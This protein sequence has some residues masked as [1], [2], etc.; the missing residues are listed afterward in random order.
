MKNYKASLKFALWM[1]P[2]VL[3]ATVISF[4]F[5]YDTMKEAFDML[6][7]QQGIPL[8]V[9]FLSGLLQSLVLL[10]AACFFGRL[11]A[12]KLGLWKPL[13]FQKKP[14]LLTL[15]LSLLGGVCILLDCLVFARA[16]PQ[17]LEVWRGQQTLLG[18]L[19]AVFYG[20]IMEELLLRL[21]V[22]SL[23]A[24]LLWKIFRRKAAQVPLWALITAN[25]LS[26]L[27]FA[28]GHLPATV[29]LFGELNG[30]L[31]LRCFLLNGVGGL[32]FGYLYRK[33]GLQYSML[34][35]MG[36]HFWFKLT[37]CFFL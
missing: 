27:L 12:E 6:T 30:L 8:P 25:M 21:L 26:A 10:F 24:F 3:L 23:F 17:I 15:A 35:H 28:A 32:C 16:Y 20:G 18:V 14:L 37:L 2:L 22:M 1:L 19:T 7:A 36:F 11:L 33:H 31:L 13:R 5:Q 9:I 29:S 34:C 4:L